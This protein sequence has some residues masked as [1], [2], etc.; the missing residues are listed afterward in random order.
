MRSRS[1][2][3]R[4]TR[5]RRCRRGFQE[6]IALVVRVAGSSRRCSSASGAELGL[7]GATAISRCTHRSGSSSISGARPE[8]GLA[9]QERGEGLATSSTTSRPYVARDWRRKRRMSAPAA[10]KV[11][12][13]C[14]R[15]SVRVVGEERVHGFGGYKIDG[16][17]PGGPDGHHGGSPRR[18]LGSGAGR[19]CLG[20]A[21][22]SCAGR[23]AD[24]AGRSPRV[25]GVQ[26]GHGA[27]QHLC[28]RP[29]DSAS[30][31]IVHIGARWPA[32][33]GPGDL[34]RAPVVGLGVERLDQRHRGARAG[35]SSAG[36]SARRRR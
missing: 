16:M 29:R 34:H 11:Q 31:T 27:V 8:V 1:P 7:G 2:A 28:V 21:A 32:A 20:Q 36:S 33:C 26:L 19:A 10:G 12:R 13:A 24:C 9:L 3:N 35:P 14:V 22:R 23:N 6:R 17:G 18:R 5:R 15:D 25:G 30:S 4:P